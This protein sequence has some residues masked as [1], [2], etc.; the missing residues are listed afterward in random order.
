MKFNDS[1]FLNQFH[2]ARFQDAARRNGSIYQS[3]E[4]LVAA[5][6]MTYTPELTAKTAQALSGGAIDFA[7]VLGQ[8]LTGEEKILIQ[9]AANLYAPDKYE[10]PAVFDLV[11]KLSGE[12]YTVMVNVF[13]MFA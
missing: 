3:S 7:G 5:Y 8:N 4:N 10:S 13:K 12:S 11:S 6:L 1:Y 9:F 2:K